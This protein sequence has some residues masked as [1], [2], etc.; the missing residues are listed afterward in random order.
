M[1]QFCSTQVIDDTLV[2]FI[3]KDK[4]S[5]NL[6]PVSDSTNALNDETDRT[7][8]RDIV[9]KKIR[10]S[11]PDHFIPDYV[12]QINSLHITKHGMC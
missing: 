8:L 6:K 1:V 2:V 9:I 11:L 12:I 10:S 7:A 4:S 3:V 5:E